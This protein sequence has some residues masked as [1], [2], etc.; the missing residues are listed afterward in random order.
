MTSIRGAYYLADKKIDYA[1]GVTY[2]FTDLNYLP[3]FKHV[4]YTYLFVTRCDLLAVEPL[5]LGLF[6]SESLFI[7]WNDITGARK[8]PNGHVKTAGRI[9]FRGVTAAV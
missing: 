7:S 5:L 4:L 6:K 9:H 3:T 2:Q 1:T 8:V